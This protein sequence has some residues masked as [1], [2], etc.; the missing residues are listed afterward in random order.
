[1]CQRIAAFNEDGDAL[2]GLGYQIAQL[3]GAGDPFPIDGEHDVT[4]LDAGLLAA[5]PAT[6]CT[7]TPPLTSARRCSSGVSGRTTTPRR[8]LAASGRSALATFSS[9]N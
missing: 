3:L 9:L 5:A 7:T 2:A 4:R 8:P 6:S 1:M